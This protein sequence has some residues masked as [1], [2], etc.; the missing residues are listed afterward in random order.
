MERIYFNGGL[1]P[2]QQKRLAFFFKY[3]PRKKYRYFR[4]KSNFESS[5]I[6]LIENANG[7]YVRMCYCTI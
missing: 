4:F 2:I 7:T 3:F 1:Q 6:I 5:L